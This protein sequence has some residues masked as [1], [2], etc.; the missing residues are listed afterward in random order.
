MTEEGPHLRKRAFAGGPRRNR[1]GF[2]VGCPGGPYKS[3]V[4]S[5]ENRHAS[6]NPMGPPGMGDFEREAAWRV[7]PPTSPKP[8]GGFC[9]ATPREMADL[10]GFS[11]DLSKTTITERRQIEIPINR[12]T[13]IRSFSLAPSKPAVRANS[14]VGTVLTRPPARDHPDRLSSPAGDASWREGWAAQTDLT[15][16]NRFGGW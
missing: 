2:G 13:S 15:P 12:S 14:I 9:L 11:P 3:K 4:A 1:G 10:S 7:M 8:K 5:A 16:G 6:L